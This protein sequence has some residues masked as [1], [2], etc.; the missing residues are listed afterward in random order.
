MG[1]F[2]DRITAEERTQLAALRKALIP[3]A[4]IAIQLGRPRQTLYAE[5]NRNT[6][7]RGYRHQ[8]AQRLADVRQAHKSP[9]MKMMPATVA[10]IEQK[11][12]L[13]H[14]PEQIARTMEADEDY[15]GPPISYETMYKHIYADKAAGGDL[16]THLRQRHKK[17]KP[18]RD[19]PD[20]RGRIKNRVG[21]EHRPAVVETRE[22]IGDIEADLVAGSRGT[23]YLVTLVDRKTR[24]VWIGFTK[25]KFADEVTTEIIRLLTG[26]VVETITFDNGKEFAGH[27]QIAAVLGCKCYFADPYSSWQRG[28]N[29]NTNG[30]IRQYFP[31]GTTLAGATAWQIAFV[32]N[33]LNSRPRKCLDFM[34]PKIAYYSRAG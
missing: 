31:K 33:R 12:R 10:Y 5:L 25:S 16:Y 34:S 19:Q 20:K 30:L 3:I 24:F 21:I 4:Q 14:S 27:E 13:E 15:H 6:G 28:T 23:G 1:Q 7:Q 9:P 29:E 17:R 18:R 11:I 2:Y 32:A 26:E 22:R 8:Q